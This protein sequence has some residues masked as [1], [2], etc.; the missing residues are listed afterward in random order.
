M[1]RDI[2]LREG[3]RGA[4]IPF[5]ALGIVAVAV[6]VRRDVDHAVIDT[7]FA[8]II[9][10]L[11]ASAEL[12]SRYRGGSALLNRWCLAYLGL[13]AAAA[14]VATGLLRVFDLQLGVSGAAESTQVRWAQVL[15]GSAIAMLVL[16][17]A[18]F[19]LTRG[20]QR[21]AAGPVAF[22]EL[23]L[24]AADRGVTDRRERDQA[25]LAAAVMGRV[26]FERALE[27]L[28]PYCARLANGSGP[29]AD[30]VTAELAAMAE[31]QADPRAK[32][33]ELGLALAG[34]YGRDVLKA[35]VEELQDPL[36]YRR[37]EVARL[38][39]HVSYDLARD[40]LPAYALQ[41]AAPVAAAVEAALVA[42]LAE[43]DAG[44]NGDGLG[45]GRGPALALGLA[46]ARRL[47]EDVLHESISGL[48]EQIRAPSAPSRA[49]DGRHGTNVHGRGER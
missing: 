12:I 32:A 49:P 4:A 17:G 41:F 36:V 19:T 13:N 23:L 35:A 39:R 44:A 37:T 15:G 29:A 10:A 26:S 16:R 25:R 20:G 48:W 42:E 18:F 21:L 6:S 5:G 31:R 3:I 47:G 8:A 11:V 38:M 2:R 27:V 30:M 9:G 46:I 40:S 1:T 33:Q 43:I 45:D 28:P 22:V 34:W 24:E 14:L 7:G